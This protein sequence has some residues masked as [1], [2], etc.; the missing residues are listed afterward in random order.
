VTNTSENPEN[1][2][3]IMPIDYVSPILSIRYCLANTLFTSKESAESFLSNSVNNVPGLTRLLKVVKVP[4]QQLW[5]IKHT[6]HPYQLY[7]VNMHVTALPEN[8]HNLGISSQCTNLFGQLTKYI[9]ETT[10]KTTLQ[11]I[12][13]VLSGRVDIL[14]DVDKPFLSRN[15]AMY[16]DLPISEAM[17]SA[18]TFG[19]VYRVDVASVCT[20]YSLSTKID[21]DQEQS[22]CRISSLMLVPC[23]SFQEKLL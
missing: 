17:V 3:V 19:R 8:T 18:V 6:Y 14:S 16:Q 13:N 15:C 10:P 9:S 2:Y 23:S 12:V 21:Q 1:T 5:R 11:H 20:G 7:P 4:P 22:L